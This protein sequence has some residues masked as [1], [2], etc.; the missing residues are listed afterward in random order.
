MNIKTVRA[1][2]ESMSLMN[3][4]FA[5]MK[6]AIQ[7]NTTE[8]KKITK[9][10]EDAEKEDHSDWNKID[11]RTEESLRPLAEGTPSAIEVDEEALLMRKLDII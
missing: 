7:E 8:F 9:R 1:F 11:T 2:N 6:K 5:E 3:I 4:N 10:I